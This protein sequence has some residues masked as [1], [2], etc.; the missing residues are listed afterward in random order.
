M[1]V[2]AY[3]ALYGHRHAQETKKPEV[4]FVYVSY[5]L[6]SNTVSKTSERTRRYHHPQTRTV[7]PAN[8]VY[9]AAYVF[10][11][12]RPQ[13]ALFRAATFITQP[14]DSAGAVDADWILVYIYDKLFTL[15]KLVAV[16]HAPK[17]SDAPSSRHTPISIH[18]D[19]REERASYNYFTPYP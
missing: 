3:T 8:N 17:G 12:P 15:L 4:T 2:L 6:P 19:I 18:A 14:T 7:S 5:F 11:L 1:D 9:P 10:V 13:T 16:R